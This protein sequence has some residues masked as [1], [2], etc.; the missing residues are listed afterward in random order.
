VARGPPRAFGRIRLGYATVYSR[1]IRSGDE[2]IYRGK[3]LRE[4]ENDR[5]AGPLSG[6]VID[7]Q[8]YNAQAVR[9]T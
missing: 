6:R 4:R 9:V 7:F 3:R 5:D 8:N 2:G 1:P